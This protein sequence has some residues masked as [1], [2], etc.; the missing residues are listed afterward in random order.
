MDEMR[1]YYFSFSQ[2]N[3]IQKFQMFQPF[4]AESRTRH[5]CYIAG[6]KNKKHL[7]TFHAIP[8][9]IMLSNKWRVS[10][11]GEATRL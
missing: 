3:F 9:L 7:N 8:L 5:K 11:G 1:K 10:G 2:L 6:E 4:H